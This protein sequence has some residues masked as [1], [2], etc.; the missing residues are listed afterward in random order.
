M[1]LRRIRRQKGGGV[2]RINLPPD[3]NDID[4]TISHENWNNNPDW[5]I[6]T[7]G[8]NSAYGLRYYADVRGLSDIQALKAEFQVQMKGLYNN[9]GWYSDESGSYSYLHYILYIDNSGNKVARGI[10]FLGN[11]T[12]R[13]IYE[14]DTLLNQFLNY[15]ESGSFY[16]GSNIHFMDI[17]PIRYIKSDSGVHFNGCFVRNFTL[18]KCTLN[19]VTKSKGSLNYITNWHE[20]SPLTI[21]KGGINYLTELVFMGNRNAHET[22][23]FLSEKHH[24]SYINENNDIPSV[25]ESNP[26]EIFSFNISNYWW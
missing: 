20:A 18:A 6:K 2:M 22:L 3:P 11:Y 5:L 15:E 7:S 24:F 17:Y 23:L 25:T 16:H 19:N 21:F 10:H 13:Q 1:S 26:A 4:I 8:I 12:G 9:L 14:S